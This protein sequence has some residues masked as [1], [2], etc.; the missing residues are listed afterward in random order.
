MTAQVET[1]KAALSTARVAKLVSGFVDIQQAADR[2]DFDRLTSTMALA[3]G[4][5]ITEAEFET[6]LRPELKKAYE[7]AGLSPSSLSKAK[8]VF[9]ATVAGIRPTPGQGFDAFYGA[10]GTE[11]AA[12]KLADGRYVMTRKAGTEAPAPKRGRAKGT[13]GKGKAAKGKGANA[14][15]S[16]GTA[17]AAHAPKP[18]EAR[19]NAATVLMGNPKAG[20]DLLRV[21]D[22][23]PE[24][25]AKFVATKAAQLAETAEREKTVSKGFL[26]LG[27]PE[28]GAAAKARA[29]K[30]NGAATVNN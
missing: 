30:A 8:T 27:S 15:Q 26:K 17:E 5:V 19:E 22:A 7:A 25:F 3:K 2:A 16:A 18:G 4:V 6:L 13:A 9:L 1:I 24:E 12:A 28:A 20:A 10:C 14:P 29:A 11:L 23:F 21:V